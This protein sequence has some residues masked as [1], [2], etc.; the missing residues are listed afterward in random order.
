MHF[1]HQVT[2]Q[3]LA[4]TTSNVSASY[5]IS[6]LHARIAELEAELSIHKSAAEKGGK[7]LQLMWGY[8]FSREL[9]H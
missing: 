7:L 1:A 3:S 6:Q 5:E 8:S 2:K 4:E 9:L